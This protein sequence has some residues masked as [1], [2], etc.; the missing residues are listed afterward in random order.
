MPFVIF[1]AEESLTP[2]HR[3]NFDSTRS[4]NV[5]TSAAVMPKS[6]D[7]PTTGETPFMTKHCGSM[8]PPYPQKENK[9]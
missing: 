2:T 5:P 8:T 9:T 6:T 4:P 3:L 7:F 1:S